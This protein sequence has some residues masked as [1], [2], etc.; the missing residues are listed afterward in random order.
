MAWIP[1]LGLASG[2]RAEEA[3]PVLEEILI[4]GSVTDPERRTVGD[5]DMMLLDNGYFSRVFQAMK[6]GATYGSLKNNFY[7]LE[8]GW[9][10]RCP[11]GDNPK[12]SPPVDLHV[13]P[14]TVLTDET[15][16]A[17]IGEKQTDPQ[18]FENAFSRL[19]RFDSESG[20]FVPTTLAELIERQGLRTLDEPAD[21]Y[22]KC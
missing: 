13:L 5:L 21:M 19:L 8:E 18:F 10:R 11:I 14:A 7:F 2:G 16:R 3:C 15:V 22:A 4:F 17:A 9:F 6:S 20:Q 12:A 1:L